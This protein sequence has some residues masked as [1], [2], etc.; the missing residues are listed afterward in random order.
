M[1]VLCF[2]D[3]HRDVGAAAALVAQAAE[4][5]LVVGAGDFANQHRGIGDCLDLLAAIDQ[6]T[7]LVP[8]NAETE[9]ELVKATA[10]WSAAIVLH[11]RGTTLDV[12]G[13]TI[14]VWGVGGGIPITPF[15]QWSYDFDEDQAAA[16]LHGCPAGALLV[17]H[18][19]PIDS[20]DR[21]S[22]G[23]IRGSRAIRNCIETQQPK[24]CVC[25]HIHSDWTRRVHIGQTEVLNA[26][27][28]GQ[29][30]TI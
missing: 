4:A 14:D 12:D 18:S 6:P 28:V 23:K 3:L 19:P 21:D 25:G 20:V 29:W 2:S 30:L 9:Q 13:R 15:G 17:T 1:N 5:D 24:A 16:M 27:P 10:A 22:S 11:G 7:I 8:G 26:G